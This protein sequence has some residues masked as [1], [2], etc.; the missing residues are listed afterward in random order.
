MME[1][2]RVNRIKQLMR[3]IVVNYKLLDKLII[4][5]LKPLL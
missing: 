4:N 1:Q 2:A 5:L 3:N